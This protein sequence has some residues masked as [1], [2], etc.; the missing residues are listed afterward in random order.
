M[1]KTLRLPVMV[2]GYFCTYSVGFVA[3]VD[4]FDAFCHYWKTK[5]E[6][7]WCNTQKNGQN[8]IDNMNWTCGIIEKEN[9]QA[10][11]LSHGKINRHEWWVTAG[12]SIWHQWT[13]PGREAIAPTNCLHTWWPSILS[14]WGSQAIG[15]VYRV[16][17]PP[18]CSSIVWR[19]VPA[20]YRKNSQ[21]VK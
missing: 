20:M 1:K 15:G 13:K 12:D 6:W 8:D 16:V 10:K 17:E 7:L 18:I 14:M 3:L 5:W 4:D 21:V 19:R 9:T 11:W 2:E